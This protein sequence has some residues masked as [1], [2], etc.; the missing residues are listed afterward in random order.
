MGYYNY[1]KEVWLMVY[2]IS[3]GNGIFQQSQVSLRATKRGGWDVSA[4]HSCQTEVVYSGGQG[5]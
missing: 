5:G 1:G 4:L 3:I 2:G